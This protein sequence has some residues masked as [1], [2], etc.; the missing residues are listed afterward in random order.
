MSELAEQLPQSDSSVTPG[1][2]LPDMERL[3][4]VLETALLTATEPLPV[5]ELKKLSDAPVDNR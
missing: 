2:G 5:S 1:E 4:H 3:K